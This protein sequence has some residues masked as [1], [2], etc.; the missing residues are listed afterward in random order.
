M[1]IVV[2]KDNREIEADSKIE[3]TILSLVVKHSHRP[4]DVIATLEVGDRSC[5]EQLGAELSS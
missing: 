3:N 5:V 1:I 2:R 4:H